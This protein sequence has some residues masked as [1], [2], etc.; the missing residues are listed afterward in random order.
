MKSNDGCNPQPHRILTATA[1]PC[2]CNGLLRDFACGGRRPP[3]SHCSR[4]TNSR[5][6]AT[7]G[8]QGVFGVRVP[9]MR[10]TNTFPVGSQRTMIRAP[11]GMARSERIVHSNTMLS[12]SIEISGMLP[13]RRSRVS[14]ERAMLPRPL[15]FFSPD[16]HDLLLAS[17]RARFAG[18]DS[19][20]ARSPDLGHI[21]EVRNSLAFVRRLRGQLAAAE[22]ISTSEVA[23]LVG[24]SWSYT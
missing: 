22:L 11:G 6:L 23:I 9:L 3:T 4:R 2:G 24:D 18:T 5:G 12:P 16:R 17:F 20:V 14:D 10:R 8:L 7:R 19:A 21:T 1:M 15:Q 13:G